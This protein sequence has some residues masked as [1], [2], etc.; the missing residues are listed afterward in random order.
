[1]ICCSSSYKSPQ[2][3]IEQRKEKLLALRLEE[4]CNNLVS[5]Q[6]NV[7]RYFFSSQ[8]FL[9]IV[10]GGVVYFLEVFFFVSK[11]LWIE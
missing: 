2:F 1:M 4:D 3:D 6:I 10:V 7:C 11:F 8:S 9:F 5:K